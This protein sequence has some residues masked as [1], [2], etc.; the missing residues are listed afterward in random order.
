MNRFN[1]V[2]RR[3][4][5]KSGVV[6]GIVAP[7]FPFLKVFLFSNSL[8]KPNIRSGPHFSRR[9]RGRLLEI[10]LKYGAEFGEQDVRMIEED[11]Y[12]GI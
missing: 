5:L 9:F 12:G 10:A 7:I 2:S 4:F 6:G 8:S 11:G 1:R 3:D